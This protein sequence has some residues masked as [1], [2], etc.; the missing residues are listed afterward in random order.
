MDNIRSSLREVRELE[1]LPVLSLNGIIIDTTRNSPL[2]EKMD[3]IIWSNRE[4][5][6]PKDYARLEAEFRITLVLL[7][8]LLLQYLK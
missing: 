1:V 6:A 7:N 8:F 2:R 3:D 4:N 5:Q